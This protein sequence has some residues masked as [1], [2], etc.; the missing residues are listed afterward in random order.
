MSK[1]VQAAQGELRPRVPLVCG[2]PKPRLCLGVILR[3]TCSA[4]TGMDADEL[5][6]REPPRATGTQPQSHQADI[7]GHGGVALLKNRSWHGLRTVRGRHRQVM[8]K[9]MPLRVGER[10]GASAIVVVLRR[11]S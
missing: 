11:A 4:N 10:I 1:G 7:R 3:H 8:V 5:A 9:A 6:A 2:S